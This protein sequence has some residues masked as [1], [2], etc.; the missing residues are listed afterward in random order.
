MEDNDLLVKCTTE[1]EKEILG[2]SLL[3]MDKL[4]STDNVM[5]ESD[6]MLPVEDTNLL[7]P[8]SKSDTM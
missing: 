3:V 5:E 1:K 2:K 4:N 8:S 6:K 7:M